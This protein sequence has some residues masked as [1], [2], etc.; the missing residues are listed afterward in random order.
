MDARPERRTRRHSPPV[1]SA[2]SAPATRTPTAPDLNPRDHRLDRWQVDVVIG[3]AD[4]LSVIRNRRAAM[5]AIAGP[6]V[7]H[8]VRRLRQLPGR[9][10]SVA[11]LARPLL[12]RR[13][14]GFLAPRRRHTRVLRRL[15]WARRAALLQQLGLQRLHPIEQRQDQVVLL[16]GAQAG[17]GQCE[18]FIG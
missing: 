15:P 11:L 17:A 4:R 16:V 13:L 2:H 14:V 18:S 5:R 10:R 8:R 9:S 7:D 12:P 3:F 1:A 6:A